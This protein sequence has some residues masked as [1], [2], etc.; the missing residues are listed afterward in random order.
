MKGDEL[1]VWQQLLKDSIP[2]TEAAEHL[3]SIR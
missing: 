3:N 2:V 1:D